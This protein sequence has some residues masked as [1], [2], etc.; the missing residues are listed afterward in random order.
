MI[1]S[2]GSS[3]EIKIRA[4]HLFCMQGF[5]G[6]G[7]SPEFERNMAEIID[8]LD[9]HPYFTLKVVAGADAICQSCPHLE[10]GNCTKPSSSAMRSMDLKVIKMLGIE[11]GTKKSA[12]E[13]LKKVDKTLNH[14]DLLDICG[15]CSWKDKCL[16]FKSKSY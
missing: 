5:Q 8:H 1:R 14:E 16:F 11:E 13:I 12:Q 6:Y 10:D 9:K 4:H 3:E 15:G 7:Y 2:T